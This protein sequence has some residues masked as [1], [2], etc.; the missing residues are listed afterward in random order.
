MRVAG[1][2]ARRLL[3]SPCPRNHEPCVWGPFVGNCS[4]TCTRHWGSSHDRHHTCDTGLITASFF[5]RPRASSHARGYRSVG[6]TEP[7]FYDWPKIGTHFLATQTRPSH[8]R[9]QDAVVAARDWLQARRRSNAADSSHGRCTACCGTFFAAVTTSPKRP[10]T[11]SGLSACQACLRREAA[12]QRAQ[13]DLPGQPTQG[14]LY[15]RAVPT[16]RSHG[17]A[18]DIEI[19]GWLP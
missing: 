2:L 14:W 6:Q 18:R 8:I 9:A 10:A 19:R 11:L 12:D 1:Q 16:Y 13:T 15:R 4:A 17:R 5:S 7:E 3:A